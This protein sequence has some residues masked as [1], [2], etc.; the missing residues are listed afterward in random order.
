MPHEDLQTGQVCGEEELQDRQ[1]SSSV[2]HCIKVLKA[3][4]RLQG[5]QTLKEIS[6][7]SGCSPSTTHRYLQA[8]Q[9]GGMVVQERRSGRYDLGPLA[10]EMGFAAL[11]RVDYVNRASDSLE[12]LVVETGCHAQIT[13]WTADGPVII[14]WERSKLPIMS[15]G[16][17]TL[18]PTWKTA[19][20]RVFLAYMPRRLTSDVLD[21]ELARSERP[22]T[23]DE[24]ATAL[25]E[26]KKQGYALGHGTY[27]SDLTAIAAPI[28]DGQGQVCAVISIINTAME[29]NSDATKAVASLLRFCR[30]T[31]SPQRG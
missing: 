18:L 4:I 27:L 3:L 8:L 17:G 7:E 16:V 21:R 13:V 11:R 26:V 9:L 30:E 5:P 23:K 19:A 31:S 28:F 20:G 25:A 29:H 14:R 2:S 15:S 10:A 6:V 1:N 24:I 12:Q 22:P